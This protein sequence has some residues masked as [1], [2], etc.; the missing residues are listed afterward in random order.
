MFRSVFGLSECKFKRGSRRG[1]WF[2]TSGCRALGAT[3]VR[4]FLFPTSLRIRALG[5]R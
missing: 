2:W 1:V 3:G 4:P 5:L